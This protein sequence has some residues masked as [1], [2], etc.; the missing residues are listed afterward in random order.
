MRGVVVNLDWVIV[1][2]GEDG[3]GRLLESASA[4]DMLGAR[5]MRVLW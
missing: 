1:D 4:G 5:S 3:V 2:V